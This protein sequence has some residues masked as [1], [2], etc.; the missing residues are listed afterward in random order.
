[1]CYTDAVTIGQVDGRDG[2]EYFSAITQQYIL[3]PSPSATNQ[4]LLEAGAWSNELHNE[5]WV[6]DGGFWEKSYELW[7]SI[8]KASW[9]DVILDKD[10]KDQIIADVDDFFNSRETYE[11]LKVPWKRGV[12]S[13][14]QE[15]LSRGR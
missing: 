11:K 3:S 12:V 8:E 5:I 14:N 1:M 9:E 7:E 4:L 13:S 15:T 10:M 6:F 2:T